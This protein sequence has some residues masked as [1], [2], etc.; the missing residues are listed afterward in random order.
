MLGV[1]YRPCCT[2]VYYPSMLHRCVLPVSAPRCVLPVS[3]PRCVPLFAPRCV[4]LFAPR[5]IL[6]A[7]R[8]DTFCSFSEQ[9]LSRKWLKTGLKPLLNREVSTPR[10]SFLFSVISPVSPLFSSSLPDYRPLFT[11][12]SSYPP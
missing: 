8:C 1:H 4:T 6:S 7:P 11:R 10:Y 2:G 12:F 3:A 5:V 9:F